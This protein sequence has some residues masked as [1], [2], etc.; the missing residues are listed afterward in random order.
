MLDAFFIGRALAE[1][2]IRCASPLALCAD[3]WLRAQTLNERVGAALGA[4][5]AEARPSRAVAAVRFL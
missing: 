1:A 4:A 3:A 5:V 2:R